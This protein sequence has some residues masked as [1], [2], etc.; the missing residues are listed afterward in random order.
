MLKYLFYLCILIFIIII[1]RFLFPFL[2]CFL[3]LYF[4]FLQLYYIHLKTVNLFKECNQFTLCVGATALFSCVSAVVILQ[5]PSFKSQNAFKL[6]SVEI[7]GFHLTYHRLDTHLLK[8]FLRNFYH[9]IESY[10]DDDDE[11]DD[12]NDDNDDDGDDD[13][14]D[15]EFRFNDVLI[16]EGHLRQNGI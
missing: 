10:D 16:Y 11:D 12:D 3:F 8:E 6:P 2:I 1:F 15:D 7:R 9:V 14:D 13:D 4:F 5:S